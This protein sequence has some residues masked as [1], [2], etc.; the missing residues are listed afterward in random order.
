MAFLTLNGITCP[1]DLDGGMTEWEDQADAGRGASGD[2]LTTLLSSRRSWPIGMKTLVARQANA[3]ERLA[4]GLGHRFSF[5]DA[6]SSKGLKAVETGTVT[7][8]GASGKFDKRVTIAASASAAWTLGTDKAHGLTLD[9]TVSL[10]F[11]TSTGPDVW[12]HYLV[13]KRSGAVKKWVD[14]VN[15]DAAATPWLV[16]DSTLGKVTLGD[17]TSRA[18]SEMIVHPFAIGADS[19]E[20]VTSF[21]GA[22]VAHPD[23][24]TL[25]AGGTLVAINGSTTIDVEAAPDSVKAKPRAFADAGTWDPGAREVEFVLH[26][27]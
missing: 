3:W 14:G 12:T 21:S 22:T 18:F 16:V 6:Y 25:R 13:V 17:G 4:K 19:G 15:N 8:N 7:F 11:L 10:W 2:Y 27:V 1:V 20:W 23:L 26:E 5:V 9:Y 24:P